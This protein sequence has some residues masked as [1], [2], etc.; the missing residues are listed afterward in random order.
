MWPCGRGGNAAAGV[1]RGCAS[2]RLG[3][4]SGRL[5]GK[6]GRTRRGG[7]ATAAAAAAVGRRRTHIFSSTMPLAMDALPSGFAFMVATVL[8]FEYLMLFQRCSRRCVFSLRPAR[9]PR[10]WWAPIVQVGYCD[11]GEGREAW[12]EWA[13]RGKGRRAGIVHT[14]QS[15]SR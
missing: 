12:G 13:R 7:S 4:S 9:I 14:P 15:I 5:N 8:A 11:G 10:G 3:D 2:R 6:R 1:A